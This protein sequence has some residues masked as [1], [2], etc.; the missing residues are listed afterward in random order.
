MLQTLMRAQ[1]PDELVFVGLPQA[2]GV[3]LDDAQDPGVAREF[4]TSRRWRERE[5]L[6][7]ALQEIQLCYERLLEECRGLLFS[8]LGIGSEIG[9][10][11]EDLR[12][13]ARYLVGRVL[14][15]G[16][17]RFVLAAVEESKPDAEW[18]ESVVMVVADKPA[19]S[20]SDED[21]TAFEVRLS[22]VA[23]RFKNVEAVQSEMRARDPQSGF[24]ARRI[25]VTRPDGQETDE[26]VWTDER[27]RRLIQTEVERVLKILS[28]H[29][30]A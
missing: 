12:V 23:R 1:E 28:C 18:L 27:S 29:R 14:E 4:A 19:E 6:V 20:W 21:V 22:D 7:L 30:A 25:T 10:L 13:R 2:V 8:A 5:R 15:P 9:Q 11:R 26:V 24:E 3:D 17:R 16:L